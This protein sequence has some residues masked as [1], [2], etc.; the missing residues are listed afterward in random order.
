MPSASIATVSVQSKH[1]ILL[2]VL[3]IAAVDYNCKVRIP[4]RWQVS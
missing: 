1:N 2:P 3:Y 4:T